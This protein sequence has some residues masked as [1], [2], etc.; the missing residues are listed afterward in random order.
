[1]IVLRKNRASRMEEM[2]KGEA[3]RERMLIGEGRVKGILCG[4][5]LFCLWGYRPATFFS[6]LEGN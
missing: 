2:A 5:F 6:F 1:M 4:V 3:R